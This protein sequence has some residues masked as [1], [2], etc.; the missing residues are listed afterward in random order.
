VKR[1]TISPGDCFGLEVTV[2]AEDG[3]VLESQDFG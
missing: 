2:F 3:S 1:T